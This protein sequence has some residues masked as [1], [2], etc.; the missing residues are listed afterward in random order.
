MDEVSVPPRGPWRFTI[1]NVLFGV[2][3]VLTLAYILWRGVATESTRPPT[4][5]FGEVAVLEY[6]GHRRPFELVAYA[7]LAALRAGEMVIQ[8]KEPAAVVWRVVSRD[9]RAVHLERRARGQKEAAAVPLSASEAT[10]HYILVRPVPAP[11]P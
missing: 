8:E 7:D 1:L 2:V 4:P 10:A 9:E 6:E 5:L 11:A 3:V